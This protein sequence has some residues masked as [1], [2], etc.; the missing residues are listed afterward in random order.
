V[1]SRSPGSTIVEIGRGIV[2]NIHWAWKQSLMVAGKEVWPILISSMS[3]LARACSC[4]RVHR[5]I[6]P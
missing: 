2:V 4:E 6:P 1:W 3:A 5:P